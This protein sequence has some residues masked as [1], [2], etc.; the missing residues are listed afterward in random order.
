MARL[1]Q[2]LLNEKAL[3]QRPVRIGAYWKRGYSALH[4]ARQPGGRTSRT[5][6]PTDS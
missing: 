6:H 3:P 4:E 2:I 5:N 1:R